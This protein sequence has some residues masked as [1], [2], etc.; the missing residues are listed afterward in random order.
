[1]PFLQQKINNQ[2]LFILLHT[3][4]GYIFNLAVFDEGTVLTPF[5]VKKFEK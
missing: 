3:F 5:L 4:D 2:A 1:M